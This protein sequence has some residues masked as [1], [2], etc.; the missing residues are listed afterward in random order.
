MLLK[1]RSN[2]IAAVSFFVRI[3][4][5][6]IFSFAFIKQAEVELAKK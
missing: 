2:E 1:S 6:K 5:D 3:R 4:D